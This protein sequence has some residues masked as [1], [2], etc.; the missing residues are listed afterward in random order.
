MR[1]AVSEAMIIG[2][3]IGAVVLVVR[4]VF[5][6]EPLHVQLLAVLF[7]S[8]VLG[9]FQLA[10]GRRHPRARRLAST[11][12]PPSP[13]PVAVRHTSRTLDDRSHVWTGLAAPPAPPAGEVE[14]HPDSQERV[15]TNRGGGAN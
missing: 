14:Q 8:L 10:L 7:A 1:S 6:D 4:A 5:G 2:V 12:P 11:A 3:S 13:A 15:S 9:G